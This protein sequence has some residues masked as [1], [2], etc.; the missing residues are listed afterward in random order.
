MKLIGKNVVIYGAGTSGVAAYGLVREKG[1]KAIVYDDDEN[2]RGATHSQCVFDGADIVVLSPGVDG[3]KDFLLDARLENVQ[4]VSELALASENCVAEQI[5]I[6]GTNGKTTTT[7]L[8]NAVLTR[9]GLHSHAVGNIGTPFSSIADKLDSTEIAVVEASSFQLENSVGFSPDVAV[10]LNVK[11]DH[12]SRHKTME[13]YVNAKANIFRFQSECDLLVYNADDEIVCDM[14]GEAIS[15]KIPFSTKKAVPCG[16]YVSSGFVCYKGKPVVALEDVDFA[17]EE[18]QN[19]LACVAVCM[20]KGISAFCVASAITDFAKPEYRRSLSTIL[21]GVKI[22]NDSKATNVSACECAIHCVGACTL[23]MGGQ[24]GREDFD[25]FFENLSENV[26]YVA[27][28]GENAEIVAYC[29]KKAGYE[30]VEIFRDLQSAL[31]KAYDNAVK[32]G[33]ESVLFSPASKSFD[34]Y[35]GYAERGKKFD[36]CVK[37]LALCR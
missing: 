10:I 8:V 36:E 3:T 27:V 9:A 12:L 20:E 23:I 30:N 7:M 22:Y 29:A 24:K 6:T 25:S 13:N 37:A 26:K 21:N 5:A 2:A 34:S 16:A 31:E 18:L 33:A 14:V 1:A 15:K 17:G 11:P 32:C 28:C 4:V 19:V 35:S